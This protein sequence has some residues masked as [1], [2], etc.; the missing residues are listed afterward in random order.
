MLKVK[1]MLKSKSLAIVIL[2]ASAG[3][4]AAQANKNYDAD[5][6][7]NNTKKEVVITVKKNW[8]KDADVSIMI[9]NGK[10]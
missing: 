10:Q 8:L 1:R 3:S 2:S 9:S 6:L 5:K 4:V 7:V